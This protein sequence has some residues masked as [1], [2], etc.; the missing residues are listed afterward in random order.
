M[1]KK[2]TPSREPDLTRSDRV[3]YRAAA[4]TTT[5]LA[6]CAFALSYNSLH[7]LAVASGIPYALSF[8]YPAVIDGLLLIGSLQILYA[9]TRG[10]RSWGGIFLV[11]LGVISSVAGNIAVS[12]PSLT[13]RLVHAASPI[14]LFLSLEALTSL[15]RQRRAQFVILEAQNVLEPPRATPAA[16]VTPAKETGTSQSPTWSPT[17]EPVRSKTVAS[18]SDANSTPSPKRP[19]ATTRSRTTGEPSLAQRVQAVIAAQPTASLE[20]VLAAVGPDV[21]PD[22]KYLRRIARRELGE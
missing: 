2:T 22:R 15:L 1:N 20:D 16:A 17:N 14:V 5:V 10:V 19:S 6:L 9:A 7:E 3:I 12:P 11:A 8:L 4:A 13:A 21:A 18:V